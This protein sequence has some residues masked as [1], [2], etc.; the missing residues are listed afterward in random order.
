MR[1]ICSAANR[2]LRSSSSSAFRAEAEI[3]EVEPGEQL[4][5]AHP[6]GGLFT[7]DGGNATTV[8]A[9]SGWW[10]AEVSSLTGLVE[11]E[12][13][14]AAA[15]SCG[16][17]PD[18]LAADKVPFLGDSP[19]A[20][21]V[22]SIIAHKLSSMDGSCCCIF[23]FGAGLLSVLKGR[24]SSSDSACPASSADAGMPAA[25]NRAASLAASGLGF[26]EPQVSE[27]THSDL[28]AVGAGKATVLLLSTD[29]VVVSA[30]SDLADVGRG[31][32]TVSLSTSGGEV[33]SAHLD[34]VATG[35][36]GETVSFRSGA[37]MVVSTHS[38]LVAALLLGNDWGGGG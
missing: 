26:G 9:S 27:S 10:H 36:G 29:G 6:P 18:K 34:F 35:L 11:T 8:V 2:R 22:S 23:L 30:A 13:L 25:S 20:T 19:W 12:G 21:A 31:E 1:R 3:C 5:L 24:S 15:G 37:G 14:E 17:A 38:D 16:I 7:A 4:T 28:V 32:A 33:A